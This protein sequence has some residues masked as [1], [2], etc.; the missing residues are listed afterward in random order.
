MTLFHPIR[1]REKTGGSYWVCSISMERSRFSDIIRNS[2]ITEEGLTYLLNSTGNGI[3]SS[4]EERYERL[5]RMQGFPRNG[6]D[7]S[8][9]RINLNTVPYYAIRRTV[10]EDGWS[11]VSLIPLKEYQGRYL[12]IRILSIVTLAAMFLIILL[13]SY[14]LSGYYVNRLRK[15]KYEMTDLQGGNFNAQLAE[16][17]QGDEIEEVYRSFNY[18]VSELRRL[19]QEHF[20]LGKN[21]QSAELRALQAQINPHFLYNTLDL[22][23]WIA[24][25]YGATEIEQIAWNLARFYRLS[26]NHGKSLLSISEELEHTQVY[27]ALQNYH[28]AGKIHL[29]VDVPEELKELACLNITLQPFVEN[30]IVHGIAE[31][32]EIEECHIT[33][34]AR[35]NQEEIEF[36]IA[37][38]GPG[39][40]QAQIEETEALDIHRKN[41]GY[42]I[43]N[44]NF[45]IKLCFGDKY[46]VHYESKVGEGTRVYV[47]IPAMTLEEAEKVIL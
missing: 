27:V 13:M 17:E 15:L 41:Q 12:M 25:D 46:G 32:S 44:I 40:T 31:H 3:V 33:I 1:A 16:E 19:M 10:G 23:N 2:D 9:E 30:C 5:M 37:D 7:A 26:L 38:D 24:M 22:I 20:R 4:N 6:K 18:M 35:Q 11:M 42:G 34:T 14:L 36:V 43:K 29:M 47:R 45:R 8:W 39:M 28:Y 21:V